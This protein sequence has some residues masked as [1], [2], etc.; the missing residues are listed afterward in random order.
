M[1]NKWKII[2]LAVTALVLIAVFM[3][4]RVEG[5][6]SY[7]LKLRGLKVSAI[8]LTGASIALATVVFQTITNNRILTP[9]IIGLDSVYMLLQTFIIFV[10]GS[11]SKSV[12]DKSLNFLLSLGLMVLFAMLLYKV[13]FRKE[14]SN[15]YHLLL[16]GMVF[17]TL[18]G[19]MTTFMQVLI[20][21][22]E[23]LV[24]QGKMF[25]SFNRMN[26]DI[27][28][29]AVIAIALIVLYFMKFA[30]Y[31]DALSLGK[32][33]AVNL[34]IP[35]QFTIKRL[36]IVVSV[37]MAVSTALV[38]PITFLGLLVA[39]VAYQL[40]KTYRHNIL[41]PG[42]ML[43]SIIALVGGQL[44]VERVFTF[45]TTLSVIINLIGGVYF[46]FLLLKEN[47]SW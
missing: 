33:H 20:D 35:Y 28:I 46:L 13:L 36:L 15:I 26:T 17:G 19:T 45:S 41:I 6:W 32:D 44:V 12:N 16:I 40:F 22:N 34:G 29:L 2:S 31:L 11:G 27:L 39:N 24:V 4:I 10:F 38:G 42:C 37:L 23:F 25:A 14:N 9:S 8:V 18:F 5:N 3:L 43:I 21:P 30:K 7:I 1:A 47:K